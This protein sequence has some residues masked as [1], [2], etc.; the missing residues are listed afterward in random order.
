MINYI[1][2]IAPYFA[3]SEGSKSV[4]TTS[5]GTNG[6]MIFTYV[7]INR[8]KIRP[9][10]IRRD[11][12]DNGELKQ[13]ENAPRSISKYDYCPYSISLPFSIILHCPESLTKLSRNNI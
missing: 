10:N 6:A 9:V 7:K 5:D 8:V 4:N 12:L 13:S 3:Y 2:F 11:R 1:K